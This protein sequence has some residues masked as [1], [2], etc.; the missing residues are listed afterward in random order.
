MTIEIGAFF[1][2]SGERLRRAKKTGGWHLGEGR[3]PSTSPSHSL[4]SR[5]GGAQDDNFYDGDDDNVL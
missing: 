5:L 3:G 4:C 1:Y 2:R